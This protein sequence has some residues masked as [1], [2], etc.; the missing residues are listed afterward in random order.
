MGR[1]AAPCTG[2][3][4][5]A[6]DA[7]SG[8]PCVTSCG[9]QPLSQGAHAAA[10]AGE[11]A[12]RQR[13]WR[14]GARPIAIRVPRCCAQL[15]Q[16]AACPYCSICIYRRCSNVPP[17]AYSA[18]RSC[19]TSTTRCSCP[20]TYCRCTTA[21]RCG[22]ACV[23]ASSRQSAGSARRSRAGGSLTP[24]LGSE[25]VVH[26]QRRR[27]RRNQPTRDPAGSPP[28]SST[29]ASCMMSSPSMATLL[30]APSGSSVTCSLGPPG[31]PPLLLL[32]LLATGL[33]GGS[34]L[35]TRRPSCRL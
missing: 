11:A 6:G 15:V 8:R 5:A 27:R 13:R 16:L 3:R 20:P 29:P 2:T 33:W 7:P 31:A 17:H 14:G 26:W 18:C 35:A 23:P 22:E 24:E 30:Q 4:A 10:P 34:L 9:R 28:G 25:G 32:L 21:D 19:C 1:A 12:G